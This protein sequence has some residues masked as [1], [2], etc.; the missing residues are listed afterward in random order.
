LPAVD[1]S[2][3]EI[4]DR[5]EPS[6]PLEFIWSHRL[7][8]AAGGAPLVT[9]RLVEG[10]REIEFTPRGRAR[11]RARGG[12]PGVRGATSP[13]PM[14]RSEASIDLAAGVRYR[15]R[16]HGAQPSAHGHYPLLAELTLADR[17]GLEAERARWAERKVTIRQR[18]VGNVYGISGRVIDNR[19]LLLLAE[20]DGSDRWARAFA[21]R[22]SE[23]WGMR[24]VLFA[25]PGARPRGSLELLDERGQ[26]L[27]AAEMLLA[28]EVD[29]DQGFLIHDVTE[30]GPAETR[31]YRGRLYLTLD[32]DG[33][34]VAVNGVTLEEL[35]RGLV[36]S[37]MPA[38]A[39]LEALKAQ[40][41]TARSNVLAQIGT[42]HLTDPYVLCS[43]VHCQAYKGEGA[44]VRSTDEAVRLTRGEALFGGRDRS[45]VDAVYSA[46]CG[47]HGEDND[48][49]WGGIPGASLRGQADLPD[50]EGRWASLAD[51]G[52]LALFL[53]DSPP[54]WCRRASLMKKGDRYRW[55]RR[56]ASAEMDR[57]TAPLGV[58]PV[59]AI[60]VARRGVSGRALVLRVE[61]ERGSTVVHGE[62]AI[63]K[64]L[65]DLMSAMFV[66]E[67]EAGGWVLRGGGWG[68]GAGMCQMG[69]IGR[70]EERQDYRQI[71]KA[72]Y[73]G[74]EVDRIY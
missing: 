3:L 70:A 29:G 47:G 23:R 38:R 26:L 19:R 43:T 6:D 61:G 16:T 14:M 41:V 53:S 1:P 31:A 8:F 20:G 37:E 56:I 24:P 22:A 9:I 45:L 11:L 36:P 5:E 57:L 73:S 54:G 46:V 59:K 49:V 35:L 30:P 51:D 66:V 33:R 74:A 17:A 32:G 55:A 65:G 58:G 40:A 48:A 71:L 18:Q 15:V 44:E 63:R 21:E 64:L 28:I 34:L 50:P 4:P 10:R 72:Y 13:P 12:T 52:R 39:P 60:S 68:H 67:R 2:V 42:R 27:A 7:N 25:E 62:L 69:A